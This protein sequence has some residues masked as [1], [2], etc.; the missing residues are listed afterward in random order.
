MGSAAA[1][2]LIVDDVIANLKILRDTLEAQGYAILAASDGKTALRI[3]AAAIPDLILLDVMMPG[4]DGYEICRRLKQ[5]TETEHIPVIFVSTMEDNETVLEGFHAGGV[6]Y[7]KKPFDIEEV[8]IRVQTH[9]RI[10]RLEQEFIQ[11]NKALQQEFARQLMEK[12]QTI[13]Q[14]IERRVEEVLVNVRRLQEQDKV[15]VLITGESGTGWELVARAIHFG[16]AHSKGPFIPVDCSIIPD[17][18]AE[19]A[20]FG[21]VKGAFAGAMADHRGYF[22]LA[23]GGTLFLDRVGYLPQDLQSKLLRVLEDGYV[24]P[25]GDTHM[26]EVAARIIATTNQDLEKTIADGTF[27]SDPYR[28]LEGLSI[29]LQALCGWWENVQL[30][31]ACFLTSSS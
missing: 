7:I 2:I 13:Q 17:N 11:K 31:A 30:V 29:R 19:S 27:R 4:T 14:E 10:N 5:N 16:G 23:D 8:L 20:F 26:K 28:K 6:D 3:A 12:N 21:H 22:E 18:L 9:L 15:S 1:K 24:T 25:V